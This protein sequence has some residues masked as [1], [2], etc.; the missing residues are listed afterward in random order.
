MI[1]AP[2]PIRAWL[3]SPDEPAVRA[4]ALVLLEDRSRD[5]A[6]VRAA[7]AASVER[8][9]VARILAGLAMPTEPRGFYVPKYGAAYHRLVALADMRAPGD[10]PRI[11]AALDRCLDVF[12]KPDGGFSGRP[13]R[14]TGHFCVTGNMARTAMVLGRGDD[15]RVLAA[16]ESLVRDQREDGGWNCFPEEPSSLDGWEALAAFAEIPPARRSA[17]VKRAIERGVEWF[18]DL[19]LGVGAGYPPW[20]RIH[21]PRHYYYDFLLGL[22]IVTALGTDMRDERLAPA[23]ALLES[24]RLPDGRW[25]LDA[26]HPDIDLEGDPAYKEGWEEFIGGVTRLEVEPAGAA[27]K[28]ATLAAM[29]VM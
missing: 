25:A 2:E 21:F 5:D 8:G 23:F 12:A 10:D 11:A 7:R 14:P 1:R 27:S 16:V 3:L 19:R 17:G 15:P 24:K 26:T 20:E 28:W 18:L 13:E 4:E 22:E 29:S 9:S 6:D